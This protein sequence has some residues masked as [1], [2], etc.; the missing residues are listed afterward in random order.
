MAQRAAY[1][2]KTAEHNEGHAVIVAP[3]K[4]ASWAA[5]IPEQ[6]DYGHQYA[7]TAGDWRQ[8]AKNASLADDLEDASRQ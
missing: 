2:S 5:A 6:I 1:G 3:A 4:R 7:P 8:A